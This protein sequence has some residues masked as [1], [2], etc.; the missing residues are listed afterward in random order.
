MRRADKRY[1]KTVERQAKLF[2]EQLEHDQAKMPPTSLA[3]GM[4][5]RNT[6]VGGPRKHI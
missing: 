3:A 2:I 6:L 4:K 1:L 5:L